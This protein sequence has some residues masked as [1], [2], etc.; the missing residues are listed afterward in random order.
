MRT[1]DLLWQIVLYGILIALCAI[2][3]PDAPLHF[4]YTEF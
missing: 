4:I 2:F 3:A 1:S